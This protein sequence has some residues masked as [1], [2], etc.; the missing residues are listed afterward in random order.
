VGRRREHHAPA[1]RRPA[2]AG[3]RAV[4]SSSGRPQWAPRGGR[5]AAAIRWPH[6][7]GKVA[8]IRSST[9]LPFHPPESP[10]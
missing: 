7:T 3:Q 8:G 10:T 2:H 5:R 4:N 1:P 9:P 6:P